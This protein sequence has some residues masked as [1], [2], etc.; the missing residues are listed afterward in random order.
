MEI[1]ATAARRSGERRV[2]LTP[3]SARRLVAAGHNVT[4]QSGAGVAAG[5]N[6]RTY[7]E[8]G[9]QIGTPS[10]PDVVVTVEPPGPADIGDARAVLGL[11]EPLDR[12]EH[13]QSLAAT[14]ATL[15]AF[16]LVPRTTR[17]QAVDVLSSQATIAGYESVL[18]AAR[19]SDRLFP[20]LTTA[21]GTIRPAS[22]VILGAGVAGL[23]AIATARRLGAVVSA[24][25]VRAA[26]AE[27]VES[28][29]AR[30]ISIDMESQDASA[31]GGYARQ[32]A[33]ETEERMLK[34]LFGHVIE[35]DAVIT[36]AA[37]P[38]RS[39]PR[40]VTKEMVSAMRPGSVVV[41]GAAATGGNC[42]VTL[43]GQ[44][45]LIEGVTVSGPL[46]L[47]SQAANHASM[48]FGRNVAAFVGFLTDEA[49]QFHINPDDDVVIQSMAAQE[50]QIV[51][52]RVQALTNT[53]G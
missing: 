20:M 51:N 28:L 38:G 2:A 9:A 22:V 19:L 21:A 13:L 35:A 34:Q 3:D 43:P 18:E 25:D 39:A 46:H 7:Q 33:E 10:S 27:Q 47:A 1:L 50:G 26:A 37:I 17:A 29:G 5:F 36:T 14:G 11:L 40:L 4:I 41:D 44:T 49:G 24:F 45:T 42:E 6:D 23:Q 30:F 31:A 15:F 12:P 8:S 48:L 32:L 16:E 53:S 52:P